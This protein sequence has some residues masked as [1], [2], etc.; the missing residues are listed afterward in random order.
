MQSKKI[1]TYEIYL[2]FK[3]KDTKVKRAWKDV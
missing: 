2:T 3:I 1:K